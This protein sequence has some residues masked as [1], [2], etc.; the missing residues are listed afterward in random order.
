MK[1]IFFFNTKRSRFINKYNNQKKTFKPSELE[2]IF[3]DIIQEHD[4]I[5]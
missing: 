2:E 5:N 3:N 4:I 1:E